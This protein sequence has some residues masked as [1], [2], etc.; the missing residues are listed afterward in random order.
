[1]T[2]NARRIKRLW[3]LFASKRHYRPDGRKCEEHVMAKCDFCG[4]E[5]DKAF[6]VTQGGTSM[7]FD[8]FE[9]AIAAMAPH[10]DHCDCRIIGH[11]LEAGDGRMFCC[12]HCAKQA[13]VG[14][15]KDRTAETVTTGP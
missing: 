3:E 10:C 2:P 15:L 11:G 7:T 12:A 9:C 8:S 5:Y 13:G 14:A 6:K 1:M 4:N